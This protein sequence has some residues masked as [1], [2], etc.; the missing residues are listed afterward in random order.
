MSELVAQLL[1]EAWDAAAATAAE[2][3]LQVLR[4]AL[5]VIVLFN[6]SH[7][8]RKRPVDQQLL[9]GAAVSSASPPPT[10]FN[11]TQIK[12]N[13]V[14][15][16]LTVDECGELP[17]QVRVRAVDER[18][19]RHAVLVNVSPLMRGHSLVVFD[20]A[21]LRP[22]RLELSYLR[23][24]VAVVH[25]ARD[26]HFALGFN[27]AGAW[28]SVNHLHLQCFFPSQLDP[29]LQLPILRQ[30]RREL[31][32][33]AGGAP[34]AVFEFPHWPMRCYGVG[35][36]AAERD[37]SGAAF[38]GVVRVA[39]A[40]LQLL[41]AR[42]IPHNVLV[43]HDDATSQ[44]L[45]VVFPRREQQE[46]GVALFSQH[47]HAGEGAEGLR[48]AVAEVAG[49]VVAGTATRFRHFSQEIYERIMRDEVSLPQDEAASI[50]D[51]W[52]RLL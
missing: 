11:F 22:Q 48:F 35:V 19:P 42:G 2:T 25:A 26:A 13:E 24:S 29:G 52:K 12:P 27:S 30:N 34:A 50:V 32:R 5:G 8:Q 6:P 36:G 9:R 49:L 7:S 46:N 23:A 47:E 4:G 15:C 17:P 40:L 16:A 41:Q 3:Q 45:V 28:S 18:P 14:L 44:P 31:F 37:S 51:E 33:A 21:Q 39:W 20:V 10:A 43:A 38:N 1:L